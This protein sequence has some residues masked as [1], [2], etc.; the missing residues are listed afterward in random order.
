MKSST[1]AANA[2]IEPADAFMPRATKAAQRPV[3]LWIAPMD[4]SYRREDRRAARHDR[5]MLRA[6]LESEG[7][8]PLT[9]YMVYLSE[10]CRCAA[11]NER[12]DATA[13]QAPLLEQASKLCVE[14]GRLRGRLHE[15]TGKAEQ[16]RHDGAKP[17]SD[18]PTTAAERYEQPDALVRRRARENT[19]RIR[20]AQSA[21]TE[22]RTRMDAIREELAGLEQTYRFH[23]L[24]Y[25]QR[26]IQ[27]NAWYRQ[28]Q[29]NYLH[30]ALGRLLRRAA[31]FTV[32]QIPFDI[33]DAE[34]FPHVA[35]E[36]PAD[37][38]DREN[39][40]DPANGGDQDAT[41]PARSAQLSL[42]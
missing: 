25:V 33:T 30:L 20:S 39:R 14:Y 40:T 10:A 26:V 28:R 5:R 24:S 2:V 29:M 34:P 11:A 38:I 4:K 8:L 19:A 32:P 37:G 36:A 3:T 6:L 18:A 1:T 9:E 21:V 22:A 31:Q 16:A 7:T 13:L 27:L 12:L 35:E 15:L 42:D 17:V 41:V 23:E